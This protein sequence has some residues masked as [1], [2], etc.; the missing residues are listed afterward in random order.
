MILSTFSDDAQWANN[1]KPRG[2]TVLTG[3]SNKMDLVVLVLRPADEQ[4]NI[5]NSMNAQRRKPITVQSR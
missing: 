1:R 5:D 4:S 2:T 3:I